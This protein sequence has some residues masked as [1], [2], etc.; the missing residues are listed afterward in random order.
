MDRERK[1]GLI[2]AAILVV[3]ALLIIARLV[4]VQGVEHAHWRALARAT[5]ERTIEIAP[6]RGTI[7]DRNGM[8]LAFDVKASAIAIDSFNMTKPETLIAILSQ[9]LHRSPAAIAKLVYH[10]SYFTWIARKVDLETAKRIKTQA[11]K[12]DAHGLIFID[13]WKRCYPQDDLA[14]NVLGFVGTDGHGLEGIELQFDKE[15]SGT[16]TVVHVVRGADG[17]TYQTETLEKG[18]PGEDIYLTIDAVLQHVCEDAID[19]GVSRFRANAGFIVLLDPHTGEVLAMAQNRRYDLNKFSQSTPDERKNLAVSFMFE[20]GSSFKAFSGLA[21]LEAG[22]VTPS[23]RFNGNDGINVA[24]HIMHNSENES[25]GTVSFAQIIEYSINV[26]MIRVAQR[27]GQDRLYKFLVNLGFGKKTGIALPGEIAGILRPV[28]KWSKLALAATSI[29]Q[30]VGVTGIQLARGMAAVANGGKL[31][32]PQIVL[33]IGDGPQIKPVL[34]RRIATEENCD[35]MRGLLRLVV[36]GG[37]GT[38]ADIPG[39][40]VAGKTG[41]A[42]KA[43]PGRGYVPGK[44]TSLFSGFFPKD[45]PQYLGLVVLDEVH[46][47]PVWGGYTAGA[48]FHNAMSR[49][50]LITHL[51]PVAQ[52]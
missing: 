50:A 11:E 45:D 22:V 27:L 29:G 14:S 16:P 37:T 6:R 25:F 28:D 51:P 26:G 21:A 42:Q 15:L 30:S 32:R 10:Q 40:D 19:R 4:M 35:K 36:T 3:G 34:I 24:G 38:R 48:I 20:P 7:Y 52:R 31:L 18:A 1:R 12:A 5:Y 47:R 9:A 41:T 43:V 8:P 23:D 17:R 46:T 33:K 44:Y 49:V 39:F 13:T 2:L